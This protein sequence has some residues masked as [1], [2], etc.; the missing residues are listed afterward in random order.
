[1][2]AFAPVVGWLSAAFATLATTL[3][4]WGGWL[5]AAF[6]GSA[7]VPLAKKVLVGLGFGVVTFV[8]IDYMLNEAYSSLQDSIATL[9]GHILVVMSWLDIDK[10]ISVI[11]SAYAAAAAT[12]AAIGAG[13]FHRGN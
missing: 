8:G 2:I 5:L 9:P 3:T 7:I 6:V 4:S 12:K 1:M 11:L 10:M 13:I